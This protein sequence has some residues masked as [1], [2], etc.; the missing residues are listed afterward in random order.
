MYNGQAYQD[1]Y[2]LNVL[3]NKTDGFFLEIGSN[4]P[5]TI[6]NTYLLET[7][8]NWKGIMVEYDA[9]FLPLYREYRPNSIPT[10]HDATSIDYKKLFEDNNVPKYVDYLQIDLEVSNESTIKTLQ[11]I[12]KDLLHSYTFA[13]I[14]FEHDIYAGNYYNTRD[15]S[16]KILNDRGYICIFKDINNCENPFEDWYVHPSLVDMDYINKLVSINIKN[17]KVNPITKESINWK[18][19][20]YDV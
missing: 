19:I 18:D 17:Y 7:Q 3:K 16:R 9:S 1:K 6:N 5:V 11:K 14:T 10:I 15:I 13:T 12:D 2:I 4:H 8:Y 20:N